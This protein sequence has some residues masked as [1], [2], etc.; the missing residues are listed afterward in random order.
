[1]ESRGGMSDAR[2]QSD[3]NFWLKV[4]WYGMVAPE[5]LLLIVIPIL[6]VMPVGHGLRAY[7]TLN[8]AWCISLFSAQP[9]GERRQLRPTL[10][11]PAWR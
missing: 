8:F 10:V 1:M 7:E 4:M 6:S 9:S 3:I 5:V 2:I 11:V